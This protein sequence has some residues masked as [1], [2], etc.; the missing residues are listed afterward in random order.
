[1]AASVTGYYA[2]NN[3]KKKKSLNLSEISR[4]GE[5]FD[6][7]KIVENREIEYFMMNERVCI[8]FM[9]LVGS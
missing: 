6:K 3:I 4:R 2:T 9:Y 5:A 8:Y 7:S 1:M